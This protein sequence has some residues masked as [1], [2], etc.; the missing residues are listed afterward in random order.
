MKAEVNVTGAVPYRLESRTRTVLAPMVGLTI[1]R[2]DWLMKIWPVGLD[3]LVLH[4]PTQWLPRQSRRAADAGG[5]TTPA[6]TTNAATQLTSLPMRR[7][8]SSGN[9]RPRRP[10]ARCPL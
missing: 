10:G 2:S 8:L 7:T 5:A 4:A 6:S 3:G 9:R 1:R